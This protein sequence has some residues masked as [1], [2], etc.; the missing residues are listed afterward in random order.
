MLRAIDAAI[1]AGLTPVKINCV[2]MRG[3]NDD[4]L[5]DFARLTRDRPIFVRFIE[6][7]P[8]IENVGLQRDAYV[9]SDEILQ[10]ISADGDLAA[11]DR[12][13]RERPGAILCVTGRGRRDRRDQ[14]AF[15]R[16]LRTLQPGST[17]RRWASATLPLRRLRS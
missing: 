3:K 15:A 2:V 5:A 11:V 17:D 8:V 10:R 14:P 6:V 16:L 13:V 12:A 4:E 9:S 1:A 7:M